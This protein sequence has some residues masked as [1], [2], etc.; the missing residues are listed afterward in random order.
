VSVDT[1][2]LPREHRRMAETPIPPTST[3][4]VSASDAETRGHDRRVAWSVVA[5]V[6]GTVLLGALV[7]G[8]ARHQVAAAPGEDTTCAEWGDG[9]HVC[10]RAE[11]AVACSLPGIACVPQATRCL[12][13]VDG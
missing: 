9:C 3:A 6:A 8:P 12:R 13:R 10:R 11:G 4:A 2:S 7:P 5:L 1:A